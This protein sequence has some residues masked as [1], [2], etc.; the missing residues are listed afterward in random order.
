MASQSQ[1]NYL[2]RLCRA[3]KVIRETNLFRLYFC[4]SHGHMIFW[5]VSEGD[6]TNCHQPAAAQLRWFNTVQVWHV[7]DPPHLPLVTN[8]S[9]RCQV[10]L[11]WIC[12]VSRKGRCQILT[13][14]FSQNV[15]KPSKG[16]SY[17]VGDL[18]RRFTKLKLTGSCACTLHSNPI[19][20]TDDS[21][22]L[23]WLVACISQT[24]HQCFPACFLSS[25]CGDY[26]GDFWRLP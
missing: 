5:L 15:T 12:D 2:Q 8:F 9:R 1:V 14:N 24:G 17:P 7:T 16:I 21:N 6:V 18:S 10:L 20:P 19:L 26:C 22:D 23:L 25:Y 11:L 4:C 3:G 13:I